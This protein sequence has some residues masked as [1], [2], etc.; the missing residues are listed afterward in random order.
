MAAIWFITGV[1]SGFG[2]EIALKALEAG[3]RVI[4]TVRH[5]AK[6][7]HRVSAIEEKGGKILELD[8]TDASAC[9]AVI[10]K[11]ESM[12]GHIDVLVNNAGVA[13]LGAVEDIE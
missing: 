2:T 5:R 13:L 4:G 8:V 7:A 9:L 12:Y 3:L 11:A 6:A 10:K 1:S